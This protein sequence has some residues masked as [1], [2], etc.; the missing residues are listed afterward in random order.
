MMPLHILVLTTQR[1]PLEHPF[2][3]EV[4]AKGFPSRGHQVSFFIQASSRNNALKQL[5]WHSGRVWVLPSLGRD[6]RIARLFNFLV[7]PFLVLQAFK[8]LQDRYGAPDIIYIRNDFALSFLAFMIRR[9]KGTRV[10]FQ[11]SFP[12]ATPQNTAWGT[13]LNAYLQQ[14]TLKKIIRWAD[15]VFPISEWMKAELVKQGLAEEK[16][17]AFPLGVDADLV[18]DQTAVEKVRMRL[19]LEGVPTAIYFGSMHP[20]RNLNFLL[21][22]WAEVIHRLPQ[23]K[24]IMLGGEQAQRE[25]LIAQAKDL[26]LANSIIFVER[27]PR[28]H[29]PTYV[30]AA[31]IGLSPIPPIPVYIISSPTKLVETL[32]VARPV[33]ANDIPEQKQ[34]LEESGGGICVPY[35]E[36][37]FIEGILQLFNNP[38]LA[39]RM[40]RCGYEYVRNKRSYQA[41]TSEMERILLALDSK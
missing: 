11:Y 19:G 38:I 4:L 23:A 26:T 41:M 24:L 29:V 40:G 30:A 35:A 17:T 16:M 6:A 36:E 9:F 1:W 25:V 37:A 12:S 33:V 20:L 10:V 7:K 32:G 21:R 5:E 39:M 14:L 18:V 27:V 28:T 8:A 3:E 15:Y 22:V 2:I 34:V 31:D 13:R